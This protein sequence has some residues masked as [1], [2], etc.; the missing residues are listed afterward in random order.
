MSKAFVRDDLVE[1]GRSPVHGKGLFART[2][3][4][5]GTLLGL[6]RAQPARKDG[7]HVLWLDDGEK[8]VRVTCKLR[9]IN[10]DRK[11]NVAYYEDLT[12]EALRDIRAGE[13]L[14]HHYG[15]DWG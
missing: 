6:C 5:E 4:E 11:P 7:P 3:I 8:P 9:Y 10:H 13:E 15:D 2:D 1:V 12:V 14:L